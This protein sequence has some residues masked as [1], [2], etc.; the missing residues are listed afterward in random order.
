M[1]NRIL[2]EIYQ[3]PSFKLIENT[4]EKNISLYDGELVFL[5]SYFLLEQSRKINIFATIFFILIGLVGNF[6]TVFVFAQ[7]R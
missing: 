6:L 1:R 2:H 4:S 7:K 5:K 3:H